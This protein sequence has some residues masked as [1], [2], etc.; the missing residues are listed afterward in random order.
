[1][2]DRSV[3]GHNVTF[4]RPCEECGRTAELV[5][6]EDDETSPIPPIALP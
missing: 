6:V 3:C 2:S 1:M 5:D 4:D